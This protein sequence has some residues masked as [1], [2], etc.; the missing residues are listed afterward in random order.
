MRSQAFSRPTALGPLAPLAA[1]C[2]PAPAKRANTGSAAGCARRLRALA[3]V[4]KNSLLDL[5]FRLQFN[6]IPAEL[7]SGLGLRTFRLQHKLGLLIRPLLQRLALSQPSLQRLVSKPLRYANDLTCCLGGLGRSAA[8][9]RVVPPTPDTTPASCCPTTG[10][11]KPTPS[12][13]TSLFIL[14]PA[15]LGSLGHA[16]HD[17]TCI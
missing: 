11:P 16:R 10:S 3:I 1:L 17:K 6:S 14:I 8:S 15:W 7:A 5:Q 4:L 9:S 12:V 13:G 2:V